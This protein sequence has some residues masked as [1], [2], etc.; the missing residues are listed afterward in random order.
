M[1]GHGREELLAQLEALEP[2]TARSGLVAWVFSGQGSQVLGMGKALYE[3][4][5]VFREAFDAAL[6]A[7]PDGEGLRAVMWGT[8]AAA[9]ERTENTQPALFVFQ[10]AA[11][12]LLRSMGYQPD[13]IVGHS[14][15]ELA[16]AVA[17][18]A[19]SL[20]DAATLVATRGRLMGSLPAGGAMIAIA[21][22]EAEV[23]KALRKGAEISGVNGPRSVVVSGDEKAV[24][25][26][27]AA[28]A[29]SGVR[30]TRLAVSHAFHSAHMDPI[31]GA[32]GEAAGKVTFLQPNIEV[33]PTSHGDP[34]T[35]RYWVDQA[36]GAVRFADAV[37]AAGQGGAT[38]FVEIG[39]Q[40]T[41]LGLVGQTLAEGEAPALIPLVERDL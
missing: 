23:A 3:R 41:L 32:L 30:T 28:F 22:P 34:G 29:K 36:R 20:Q 7:L 40:S 26:V 33:L 39:P 13:R 25:A 19:M 5:P 8:D 16:G 1:V 31:L 37:T 38:L 15:G 24:E 27:A 11:N 17:A 6:N 21:A 9:L 4:F 18:G 35:A 12:A 2:R 10:V 14:I